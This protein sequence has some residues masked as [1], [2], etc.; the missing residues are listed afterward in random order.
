MKFEALQAR[1]GDCLLL[2]FEGRGSDRP[3][4]LLVDGGPGRVF[5]QFLSRRLE[6][7]RQQ[8]PGEPVIIDAVMISHIDEDHILGI[9]DLFAALQEA[10][11][12]RMPPPYRARWLLH[13]SFDAMAGEGE[14]GTARMLDGETVLASFGAPAIGILLDDGKDEAT[15]KV[16]ASYPQGSRLSTLAAALHIS[17]NPP[18]QQVLMFEGSQPRT[19][20][21]G[22]AK[23]RILG[24][25]AK[26]VEKLRAEWSKWR[27]KKQRNE[28]T[29]E[30]ANALAAYLDESVPNLSSIV[31]LVEAGPSRILLTGDARGDKILAG[32]DQAGLLGRSADT[33]KVDIL[34]LPHHGSSRNV[35]P[36]FFRR[37]HADHYVASGDGTYGNPDR[38]TLDWIRQSRPE[39]GYTLH[40][41][42][43]ATQC[44]VTHEDWCKKRGKPFDAATDTIQP[45]VD[46][47]RAGGVTVMEGP[48]TIT[49]PG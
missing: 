21:I 14:G 6:L 16:L 46:E 26:E 3:H 41:T 43:P 39:G 7:E 37:I 4:R 28:A 32:L 35:D 2:T 48:V 20:R 29:P 25:L 24:P 8:T 34:K 40:L 15:A 17:R 23:L 49:L 5:D 12:R 19:L 1:Y 27:A 42:Y 22:D 47:L 45:I 30:A 13:N 36:V 11:Q 9:L 44:D 18:D 38:D 31:A 10:E 33:L